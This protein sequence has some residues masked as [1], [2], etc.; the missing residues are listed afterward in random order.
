MDFSN[1]LQNHFVNDKNWNQIK[2]C[3]IDAKVCRSVGNNN[4][5]DLNFKALAFFK[6]TLP[7]IQPTA[8]SIILDN[9]K[10]GLV[11]LTFYHGLA[12]ASHQLPLVFFRR[13][14]HSGKSRNQDQPQRTLTA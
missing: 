5:N 9:S 12:A 1:W 13:M 3:L 8:V 2:S 10:F 11:V 14:Q 4:N 7:A 6:N